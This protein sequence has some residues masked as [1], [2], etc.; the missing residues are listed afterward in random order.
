MLVSKTLSRT[1]AKTLSSRQNLSPNREKITCLVPGAAMGFSSSSRMSTASG[2]CWNV[3]PSGRPIPEEPPSAIPKSEEPALGARPHPFLLC[4][5][6]Q[7]SLTLWNFRFSIC[8]M[9]ILPAGCHPSQ[10]GESQSRRREGRHS[11][12]TSTKQDGGTCH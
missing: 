9:G 7:V 11:L 4:D 5:F 10:A 3:Y 6:Q 1:D 2:H 8:E 12:G